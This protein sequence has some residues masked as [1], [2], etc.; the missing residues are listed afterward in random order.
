MYV[1]L[2][3]T[4]D[5]SLL[6]ST[7]KIE[8]LISFLSDMHITAAAIVDENLFGIM[9]FYNSCIKNSIK[10]IIGLELTYKEQQI[11]CYAKNYQGYQNLLKLHTI[12]ETREVTPADFD[13][14]HHELKIILPFSSWNLLEELGFIVKDTYL[15]YRTEFEKNNAY[16][17]T[18]NVVYVRDIRSLKDTDTF[19]LD[20]LKMI[21]QGLTK[22]TLEKSNYEK[23]YFSFDYD[24]EDEKNT[25][26]FIEDI[27]IIIPKENRYIPHYDD[28]INNS[29]EYLVAL[30]K[31]GLLRRCKNNIPKEYLERLKYELNTIQKMGFVDYFL[32]VYDYVRFAKKNGILVGPGRGSAAGSIV[33]YT[34]G[35]TDVDPLKYN[36]LFER[37]LNPE[38]ITMPDIDIDFEYTR[39]GEVIQ[40]VKER[41]GK[42]H[43]AGI[44]T[45]G[46]LGSKLVL[47]DIGKCLE[48]DVNLINKFV[49]YIDAKKTL[50]E[51]LENPMIKF[52]IENNPEIKNWYQICLKLE[53]LKR[54]ISTH[55][56]G[57]VI[58]S[59]ALDQVIPICYS[60][61]E[62]LT[63]VT[64]SYLEEL[65]L[66][67]MDFLALRNLTIIKN[68]LDLIEK[69]TGKRIDLNQISLNDPNVLNL[70][71]KAD[72]LGI[73]QFESTGMTNFLEKLKPTAFEDLVAALALY[74]PGPMD[75]IDSFIRRKEGKEKIDYL[76]PDLEDVLKETYG[77]IVYQEQIMQILSKVGGFSFAESDNIRRAMS[78][79]KKEV[80]ENAKEQFIK[81]AIQKKYP[82]MLA[83]QIYE[84]ILKFAN[85]GFNKAHSVS[86]ALIGY[87]MAYL[88]VKY[89]IYY[90][91]NLLNMSMNAIEKTK[92]Y[93]IE[94]KKRNYKITHPDINISLDEYKIQNNELV[95][96][97]TVIKNLG[98]ESALTILEE[99]KKNGPFLDFFDFVART[100]GKSI[101]KKTI[102]CLIDA[103]AFYSMEKSY[104]TL[105]QNIDSAINYATLVSDIDKSLMKDMPEFLV[106]KPTLKR[107]AESNIDDR[108]RELET[109]G[110]YLSNHPSSKFNDASITKIEHIEK[111]FDKYIKCIVVIENIKKLETKKKEP[112]AFVHASDETASTDFVV[113]NNVFSLLNDLSKNALVLIEGRVT[114]RF[115]K[116]QVNVTNIIKQ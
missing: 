42:D 12:K 108:T 19:Y 13:L 61:G 23:N 70:F 30:T 91:A 110:F 109:F 5:Y 115:D 67:K 89:P 46:T 48:L 83:E 80:I 40:Y 6:K 84:L 44:M 10:P 76:H 33:S 63:G 9:E 36:L 88:K 11:Y 38:R 25:Q 14:Y 101:N 114:K 18:E 71:T 59:I 29:Y 90:I 39:R 100:Y 68:I 94:A 24:E 72:T 85:Y 54:H 4:T 27:N 64:M 56:A 92:E 51:N 53:G 112:M 66:L 75:N 96:P 57:I 103:G 1:P 87:Q 21:D 20:Y 28:K 111:F 58:S 3:I 116:Y 15:G 32:I 107:V 45:F 74:R 34:L 8:N 77:I 65:G 43:V 99:R 16:I 52:H 62:M 2:K 106:M 26:K 97:F 113:F 93:I 47:R 69:D 81:G 86:Y 73:F 105:K 102:E 82:Q 104:E 95:L 31:K 50:K 17:K 37:F 55:A 7:I 35:I 22:T 41:Y 60:G 78:K 79:K 49:S 98:S